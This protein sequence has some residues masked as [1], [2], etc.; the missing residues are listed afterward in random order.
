MKSKTFKRIISY[1]VEG[2]TT[3]KNKKIKSSSLL[4]DNFF[5]CCSLVHF[6]FTS[7]FVV[8]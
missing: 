3:C 8:H 1:F 2:T 6:L 5:T 4:V 7:S